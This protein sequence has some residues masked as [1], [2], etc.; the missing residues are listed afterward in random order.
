MRKKLGRNKIQLHVGEGFDAVAQRVRDAW[1]RAERGA[2]V[3]EH[4]VTFVSW[5]A[6][7]SVIT[8]KRFELLRYVRRHP[9]RSIAALARDIGRDY[10]RVYKDVEAL[11]E[12][13]LIERDHGL[14]V[15]FNQIQATISI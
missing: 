14:Y 3:H 7:S 4:H 11:A 13:G 8:E 6:I 15:P 12:I 10:K 9:A 2:D 1:H 5:Q